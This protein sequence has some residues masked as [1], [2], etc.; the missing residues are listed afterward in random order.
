MLDHPRHERSYFVH[1][2]EVI[3]D[4]RTDQVIFVA[5]NT[6]HQRRVN[7]Y[8][9]QY[10]RLLRSEP[11]EAFIE[12][13]A[14]IRPEC[15]PASVFGLNSVALPVVLRNIVTVYLSP[16]EL[17]T[18]KAQRDLLA[19][20]SR[21]YARKFKEKDLLHATITKYY[22]TIRDVAANK[23][24]RFLEADGDGTL[25]DDFS[26]ESP[27]RQLEVLGDWLG[28][29]LG[30]PTT[31]IRLDDQTHDGYV[32]VMPKVGRAHHGNFCVKVNVDQLSVTV[33]TALRRISTVGTLSVGA[34]VYP[35]PRDNDTAGVRFSGLSRSWVPDHD[36]HG[37][38]TCDDPSA[39]AARY[40]N[41]APSPSSIW[42]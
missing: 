12:E 37:Q 18:E 2:R 7:I 34:S 4:S 25:V 15:K 17:N 31:P 6:L 33:H 38:P 35:R 27:E 41:P 9:P 11:Y 5:W 22:S 30:F 16:A 19:E 13:T 21:Q 39:M 28:P 8:R 3:H 20:A 32:L 23:R 36:E 24:F 42:N 1:K 40:P 14:I 26:K 29:A 10:H